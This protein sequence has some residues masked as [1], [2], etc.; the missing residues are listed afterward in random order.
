V[1]PAGRQPLFLLLGA[2]V[3]R[4]LGRKGEDQPR[5]ARRLRALQQV[6]VD[7]L[8]RVVPHRQRGLPVEQLRGAREQQLQVVVQLGHRADRAAAG[9]HRVGLVD[10]D[11]RRHAVHAVDRR[12]VHAVQELPRVGAEGLDVAA[13]AFGVQRVEDQAALARAAGPG[14]HRQLAG[15]DVQVEVLQVVLAGAADADDTMSQGCF[16]HLLA[17]VVGTAPPGDALNP[18]RWRGARRLP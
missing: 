7:G 12:A 15:A 9:A 4:Q 11:G 16:A 6:G 5:V 14:D 17:K 18:R 13:L 8:R 3:G 2:G 10:G 1:K